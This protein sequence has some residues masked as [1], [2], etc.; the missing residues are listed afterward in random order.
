MSS[1]GGSRL[2]VGL[3]NP[4]PTYAKTRHNYGFMVVTAFAQKHGL[5][6][7]G[8]LFRRDLT[9]SGVCEGKRVTLLLPMSYMNLSGPTV[10]KSVGYNKIAPHD[11]LVV[12]DDAD[13]DFGSMRIKPSG[14]S[15][16]HNGLKSIEAALGSQNYP[17]LR[18]GIR[19]KRKAT[20]TLESFV[21]EKFS[22]EEQQ[23]LPEL[24]DH[25]VVLLELWLSQ[26][27]GRGDPGDKQI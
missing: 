8:G 20:Q 3:G 26:G 25:G 19:N 17:R 16:G 11:L 10:A 27:M 6:L 22:E 12:V 2:I 24:I 9:A 23:E 1:A 18:M 4:G 13:T 5:R 7:K 15:G 14:S 21:L